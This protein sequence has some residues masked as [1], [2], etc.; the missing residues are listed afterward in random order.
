[1]S[2]IGPIPVDLL[3]MPFRPLP[4]LGNAHVQTVLGT[5]WNGKIPPLPAQ[6]RV[7]LL[8][9]GDR[10]LVYESTPDSWQPGDWM[11]L[12]VH[13]MGGSYCSPSVRR[14]ARLL[15]AEGLRVVR[16]NLRGAGGSWKLTRQ[17]Y[18]AGNSNDIRTVAE[19]MARCAPGSPLVLIGLS[20]GGNIVLKLAGEA[21]EQPVPH[22]AGVAALSAPIDL[23]RCSELLSEPGNRVYERYYLHKLVQTACLHQKHFPDLPQVTF[24]RRLTLRRFDDMHTAPRWGFA[25][26]LDYYRRASALPW[27][28]RIRVPAFLLTARDDPFIAAEAYDELPRLA[29]HNVHIADNGGHLGFLGDDGAGGIRW[30]ERRIAAWVARLRRSAVGSG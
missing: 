30:A 8:P 17:L 22:L 11:A 14:T 24:P 18:N 23:V 3:D 10:L 2:V 5:L 28:P 13:G 29:W 20:L 9:D 21:S 1:M 12:L 19:A 26:A 7:I 15:L 16:V 6:Q 4:W 27:V 25:D